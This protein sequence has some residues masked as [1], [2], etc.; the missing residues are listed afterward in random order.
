MH[1]YLTGIGLGTCESYPKAS[2]V[3]E[4]DRPFSSDE[5]ARRQSD[6]QTNMQVAMLA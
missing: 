1:S 5:Y 2:D 6:C 4:S 3:Y